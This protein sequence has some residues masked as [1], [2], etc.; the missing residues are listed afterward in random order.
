MKRKLLLVLAGV[1]LVACSTQKAPQA[2]AV[3]AANSSS[4]SQVPDHPTALTI[5]RGISARDRATIEFMLYM[6]QSGCATRMNS[7]VILGH[8]VKHVEGRR[9]SESQLVKDSNDAF[10]KS[11]AIYSVWLQKLQPYP[12]V[13][14]A[15][16]AV[17]VAEYGCSLDTVM[18]IEKGSVDADAAGAEYRRAFEK[19]SRELHAELDAVPVVADKDSPGLPSGLPVAAPAPSTSR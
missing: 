4:A 6:S 15:L 17:R 13:V 2:P 10:E 12:G 14:T 3:S 16:K 1:A 7:A 18:G 11:A 5:E 8:G 9:L 19:A